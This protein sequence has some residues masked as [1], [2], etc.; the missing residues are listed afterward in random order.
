[1]NSK[2]ISSIYKSYFEKRIESFG[3]DIKSLWNTTKGQVERFKILSEIGDL[4]NTNILDI[5]CGFGDLYT[6]FLE[7]EIDVSSYTGIDISESAIVICNKK[8]ND[9]HFENVSVF[10][11]EAKDIDYCFASGIFFLPSES[12]DEYTLETIKR[13][14]QIV[15]KGV[16]VNFLSCYSQ[17]PDK[18]SYYA[19]PAHVLQLIQN[20]ISIKTILRHDYRQNDFTVYI[21]K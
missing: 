17:H 15:H 1:M 5:G 11:F 19:N 8:H 6:Y 20:G 16:A 14:F 10:E 21:Y 2:D 9:V 7:N 3:D 4:N 18:E 13:M 12:W